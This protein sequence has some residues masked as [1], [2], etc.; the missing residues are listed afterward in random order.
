MAFLDSLNISGSALTA[1]RLRMDLISE[2]LANASATR[3][4]QGGPYRRK[5]AVY[6]SAG[7]ADFQRLL[8]ES[9]DAS[10]SA[11]KGV[12]VAEIVED[13]SDFTPVYDPTHPDA[14]EEGYVL[15]PN[16]DPI[17][18]TIDMMAA[19]RAYEANLTAFGA[20]MALK[21]LEMGR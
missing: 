6:E 2:N 16:V 11:G 17:K 5:M 15:M 13:P 8:R 14:N 4:E 10:E 1:G 7:G 9:I 20:V 18:E 3:T 12:R 21:A 19:A